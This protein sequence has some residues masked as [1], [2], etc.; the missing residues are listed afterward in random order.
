L[1]AQLT[2]E[3]P[4]FAADGRRLRFSYSLAA[5]ER[6]SGLSKVI[7]KRNFRGK[8]LCVH[9]RAKDG[10]NPLRAT[11]ALGQR[12]VYL[13]HVG[14]RRCYSHKRLPEGGP[15]PFNQVIAAAAK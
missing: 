9:F 4:T 12:Y 10:D 7:V 13:E 15:A 2:Q 14:D 1:P 11:A 6:L 3:I 5:I 8:I